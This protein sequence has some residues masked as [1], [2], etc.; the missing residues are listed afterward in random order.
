MKSRHLLVSQ[1]LKV[2]ILTSFIEETTPLERLTIEGHDDRYNI[3]MI[4]ST[5]SVLNVVVIMIAVVLTLY[6]KKVA[7]LTKEMHVIQSDLN[8]RLF[9]TDYKPFIPKNVL[10]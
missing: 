9:N 4:A 8:N 2:G 5:V 7:A 10:K 3:V 1:S 6:L